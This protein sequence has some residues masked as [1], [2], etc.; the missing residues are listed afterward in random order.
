VK[1]SR[2]FKLAD[3][4]YQKVQATDSLHYTVNGREF[5][6]DA[7]VTARQLFVADQEAKRQEEKATE[8][9]PSA[10]EVAS[11]TPLPQSSEQASASV[12]KQPTQAEI[13]AALA[14]TDSSST[15]QPTEP[16]S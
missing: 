4:T 7:F 15:T 12:G 3:N 16:N 13:D 2:K 10:S 5:T 6:E 14:G 9:Q 1:W 8:E 11:D